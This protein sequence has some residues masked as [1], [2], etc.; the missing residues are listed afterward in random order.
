MDVTINSSYEP[1][2]CG[3]CGVPLSF[4]I[5]DRSDDMSKAG[6]G[7]RDWAALESDDNASMVGTTAVK[8]Q[9]RIKFS[10]HTEVRYRITRK[11]NGNQTQRD[12]ELGKHLF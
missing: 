6:E 1:L 8:F 2:V 9:N 3:L 7:P 4:K 12:I 5:L 10:M 11:R